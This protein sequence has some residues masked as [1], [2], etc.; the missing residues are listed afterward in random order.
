MNI[1]FL[2]LM[3][4]GIG[5]IGTCLVSYLNR[6]IDRIEKAA[7]IFVRNRL[8]NRGAISNDFFYSAKLSPEDT[9]KARWLIGE[10]A[11]IAGID[12]KLFRPEDKLCDIF[13]VYRKELNISDEE[14]KK[15][16]IDEWDYI[17]VFVEGI[18][19]FLELRTDID[20]WQGS[21]EIP[22]MPINEDQWDDLF[23]NEKL[24]DIIKVISPL[25]K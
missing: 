20:R 12:D 14:W 22:H 4:F 7:E 6:H 19:S 8:L 11:N 18:M 23:L 15:A 24:I 1:I 5:L 13:R 25:L 21:L 3:L 17:E 2:I 10:I 9:I 16:K